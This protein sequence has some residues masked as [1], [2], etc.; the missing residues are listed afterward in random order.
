MNKEE[1]CK[2]LWRNEII[3]T[4]CTI[5]VEDV[6]AVAKAIMRTIPM[7]P[8]V[9]MYEPFMHYGC[10]ACGSCIRTP[11]TTPGYHEY[12][13]YCAMCGQKIDWEDLVDEN[14]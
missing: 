6:P 3:G 5:S 2:H 11:H 14:T 10:P 7:K 8:L 9:F 1:M 12:Q 13:Q 4:E